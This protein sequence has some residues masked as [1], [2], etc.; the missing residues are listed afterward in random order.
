MKYRQLYVYLWRLSGLLL[1]RTINFFYH[2]EYNFFLLSYI[3]FSN[4]HIASM[5][6][7]LFLQAFFH[8][9]KVICRLLVSYLPLFIVHYLSITYALCSQARNLFKETPMTSQYFLCLLFLHL[10]TNG[11]IICLI[12]YKHN[13][14][15]LFCFFFK[16]SSKLLRT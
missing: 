3:P 1:Q 13:Q 4:P 7:H 9:P 5:P 6:N 16:Q 14:Q 15:F 8:Y 10:P 11:L 12:L 2:P